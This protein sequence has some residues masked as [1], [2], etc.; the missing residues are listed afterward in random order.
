MR[1]GSRNEKWKS[2]PPGDRY[3]KNVPFT[4]HVLPWW[5]QTDL[6]TPLVSRTPRLSQELCLGH[7]L[8]GPGIKNKAG[9]RE[10]ILE[11]SGDYIDKVIIFTSTDPSVTL[12]CTTILLKTK[13]YSRWLIEHRLP[14]KRNMVYGKFF[15]VTYA[16]VDLTL[17]RLQS[18]LQRMYHG[19][20]YARVDLNPMPVR[21]RA[22]R[23]M[24]F[25]N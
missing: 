15:L 18:R 14:S 11:W 1:S 9:S 8:R 12:L 20:S 2:A 17:C 25:S 3:L 5:F 7:I 21:V 16:W 19:Q 23:G 24:V 4:W 13:E 22:V 6:Q 10:V